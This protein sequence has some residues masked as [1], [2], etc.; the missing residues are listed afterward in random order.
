[1]SRL[2]GVIPEQISAAPAPIPKLAIEFQELRA[3]AVAS[4]KAAEALE[5]KRPD[6]EADDR[7]SH[8]EAVRAGKSDPGPAAVEALEEQ[9][10]T[11]WRDHRGLQDACVL[12]LRE[13]M[14][15]LT[16][17]RGAE[18]AKGLADRRVSLVRKTSKALVT[19]EKAITEVSVTVE[20]IR[21]LEDV[22]GK[23]KLPAGHRAYMERVN[24]GKTRFSASELISRLRIQILRDRTDVGGGVS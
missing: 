2:S 17:A 5:N 23:E 7:A 13:L 6:A 21:W 18:W 14:G 12:A 3:R 15:E 20:V 22:N 19:A 9:I 1:M 4:G 11:A 10:E 16:G 8:A 24:V